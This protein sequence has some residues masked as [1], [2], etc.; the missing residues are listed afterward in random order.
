MTN[1]VRLRFWRM[2]RPRLLVGLL[3]GAGLLAGCTGQVCATLGPGPVE[4]PTG[5]QDVVLRLQQ[6]GGLLPTGLRVTELPQ[7]T[8]YGDGTLLLEPKSTGEDLWTAGAPPLL[9]AHLDESAVQD[10]L[11]VAFDTGCLATARERYDNPNIFDAPG[12]TFMLNAGGLQKVVY[13]YALSDAI[14]A[15]D[16][17]ERLGVLRL[18]SILNGYR[19]REDLGATA[20]YD[21]AFYRVT[22]LED[23]GYGEPPGK[24]MAWPWKDLMPDDWSPAEDPHLPVALL[25]RDQV[26]RLTAVPSGGHPGVLVR[27]PGGVLVQL[28]VRPLLP[29][30]ATAQ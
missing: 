8:L 27:T 12:T 16:Q 9:V 6:G 3:M 10:L 1:S 30:E 2:R 5:S 22:L 23:T 4:H 19:E 24:P 28:A 26:A 15:P 18:A 25:S 21:P 14:P 7:F 29:E 20:A 13:V 11:R 17:I